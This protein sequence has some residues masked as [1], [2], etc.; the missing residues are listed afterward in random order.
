MTEKPIPGFDRYLATDSGEIID[1][2]SRYRRHVGERRIMAAHP[3]GW[4]YLKVRIS[5]GE[6]VLHKAVHALVCVAF[7][8]ARPPG[9]EVR[10]LDG[11]Q[12]NN[13]PENLC[14]GTPTENNRDRIR[15]GTIPRGESNRR[16]KFTD[17]QV[18]LMRDRWKAGETITDLASEYGVAYSTMSRALRRRTWKHVA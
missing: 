11:N 18:R 6:R 4:G 10:H 2:R 5:D 7:H 8:G 17:E 3:D 9:M 12:L 13:R 14:W 16:S 15:H 1:S